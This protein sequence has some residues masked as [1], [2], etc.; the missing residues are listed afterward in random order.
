M[1]KSLYS[2]LPIHHNMASAGHPETQPGP[3]QVDSQV[4]R[5]VLNYKTYLFPNGHAIMLE[6]HK[7]ED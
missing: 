5:I 3:A 6:T 4:F 7:I 1:R 2:M